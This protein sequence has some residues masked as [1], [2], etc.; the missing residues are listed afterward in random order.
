MERLPGTAAE[1]AMAFGAGSALT[2]GG[3]LLSRRAAAARARPP[4]PARQL[5]QQGVEL[6]P[7]Q[8]AG[9]V[10]Q[11]AEDAA[12]SIPVIGDSIRGARVRGL[13]SF[14]RAALDRSLAPIGATL[15]QGVAVGRDGLREAE[16]AIG[17]HYDNALQRVQ[18]A[19]D[20]QYVGE[21]T[22]VEQTPNLTA[23][24][25]ETL[26]TIVADL[27]SRFGQAVPGRE[28]KV[29]D[30]DLGKAIRAA[31]NASQNQPGGQAL[32]R[33]L[34]RLKAAH[35]DLLGR[36]D[37]A[38]MAAVRQGDEATAN[39]VRIRQASQYTGSSARNGVFSPADLNRSVQGMDTS[40]GNRAFARGDAMMQ[41]LTDPAMQTLPATV[42]DSGTPLR[43]L[44]TA[45][46]GGAGLAALGTN[47]QALA[48]A[49]GAAAATAA[50]YSAPVQR[51][52]NEV[53]RA[54][55]PGMAREALSRL[56]QLAARDPAFVP[57]YTEAARALGVPLASNG[58]RPAPQ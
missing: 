2:A 28:W 15:P 43:S 6:T 34:E 7:G 27:R 46:A 51:M 19:P 18:V 11:R 48:V 26:G 21:L 53:Y 29:L 37:P 1:S 14:N 36:T 55:T 38:V 39:L 56:A 5:S 3:N 8:M 9:G 32:T 23:A 16:Q 10:L 49:G 30:S 4:T 54:K 33:A 45:G 24:Q 58:G 35:V 47:P 52:L 50:G 57:A 12:T 31:D 44:F 25:R 41:D 17:A 22:A 20:A 40:A 42:P 13:E